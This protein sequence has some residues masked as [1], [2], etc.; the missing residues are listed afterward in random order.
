MEKGIIKEYDNENPTDEMLD[1]IINEY[2]SNFSADEHGFINL[3]I[4]KD[5]LNAATTIEIGLRDF[6]ILL[7]ATQTSE[8]NTENQVLRESDNVGGGTDYQ[9]R[10]GVGTEASPNDV[11]QDAEWN[12][13]FG[14]RMKKDE[15]ITEFKVSLQIPVK[16]GD[17]KFKEFEK[18]LMSPF[19]E[20]KDSP[21]HLVIYAMQWCQPV[22]DGIDD[23]PSGEVGAISEG[24]YIQ[25]ADY[26]GMNMH[27]ASNLYDQGGSDYNGGKG[28]GKMEGSLLQNGSYNTGKYRSDSHK[29][30]DLLANIGANIFAFRAGE[31]IYKTAVDGNGVTHNKIVLNWAA[32]GPGARSTITHL[33]IS[34]DESKSSEDKEDVITGQ[35]IAQAGR[36][37]NLYWSNISNPGH[38]HLN[39]G[40][41]SN[42]AVNRY[43]SMLYESHVN[44]IDEYNFKI[45]PT[46][47]FPLALPCKGELGVDNLTKQ[48][49]I[50][51]GT[52]VVC[53]I[54]GKA[55]KQCWAAWELKCPLVRN[56]NNGTIEDPNIR[57]IQAQ[58][59]Y[60]GY[61]V[62]Q[63]QSGTHGLDGKLSSNLNSAIIAYKSDENLLPSD[64]NLT[65]EL[66][67]SLNENAP[68]PN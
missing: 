53:N 13:N 26:H 25:H 43:K 34:P 62:G 49:T 16:E 38:V 63:G 1:H 66:L 50:G 35:V 19:Y 37:G 65:T 55:V 22:W 29:G 11:T 32:V 28:Y 8:S 60:L 39:V 5:L 4:P 24:S 48:S 52:P 45:F 3:K 20:D 7:E 17:D 46:N 27:I 14:W 18:D 40:S 58:L 67:D 33:H 64:K 12:G 21:Y 51:T 41:Y 10:W 61:Y 30:Y 2:N 56:M 42:N 54:E 59:K 31:T 6:P 23:N 36:S 15:R 57:I 68:L 47:D 44:L 9:I